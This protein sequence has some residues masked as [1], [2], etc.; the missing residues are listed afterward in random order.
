MPGQL[1]LLL[2]LLRY[3]RVSGLETGAVLP[4][5][6][7]RVYRMFRAA[8]CDYFCIEGMANQ[9]QKWRKFRLTGDFTPGVQWKFEYIEK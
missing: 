6:T 9:Q 3:E 2:G 8:N 5:E 1:D 4:D 7:V